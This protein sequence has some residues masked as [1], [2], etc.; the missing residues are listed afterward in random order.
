MSAGAGRRYIDRVGKSGVL[1]VF[2]PTGDDEYGDPTDDGDS[3]TA[4]NVVVV[5][6]SSD[7]VIATG[8]GEDEVLSAELHVRDDITIDVEGAE[9]RPEIDVGGHTYRIGLVDPQGGRPGIQR[10]FCRK[11]R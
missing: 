10:L 4:I 6:R 5:L 1:R 7:P 9:Q 2:V 8:S 11:T 3:E